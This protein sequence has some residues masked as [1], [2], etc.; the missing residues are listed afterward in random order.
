MAQA[1]GIWSLLWP[2]SARS[3]ADIRSGSREACTCVQAWFRMVNIWLTGIVPLHLL[4]RQLLASQRIKACGCRL[5]CVSSIDRIFNYFATMALC[6]GPHCECVGSDSPLQRAKPI[7][8]NFGIKLGFLSNSTYL[9]A[10]LFFLVTMA[11]YQTLEGSKRISYLYTFK[12]TMGW[13]I[14]KSQKLHW[15]SGAPYLG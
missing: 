1:S 4:G 13:W 3:K 7:L 5:I 9:A 11:T 8:G 6:S 10:I 2:S 12:I 15:N 14:E